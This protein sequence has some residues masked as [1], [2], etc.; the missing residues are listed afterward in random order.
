MSTWWDKAQKFYNE[1]GYLVIASELPRP[2][3]Y[4]VTSFRLNGGFIVD[5]PQPFSVSAPS[6]AEDYFSQFPD[7]GSSLPKDKA[8]CRH[9]YRIVTD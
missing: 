4:R 6:T 5:A 2:T 9:F 8:D 1:R 7:G 3:G